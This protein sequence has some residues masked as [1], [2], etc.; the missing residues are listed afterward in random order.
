MFAFAQE[1][2]SLNQKDQELQRGGPGLSG[3]NL[4]RGIVGMQ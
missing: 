4:A 2:Q 3:P 1:L